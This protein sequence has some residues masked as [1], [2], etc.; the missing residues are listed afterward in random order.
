MNIGYAIKTVRKSLRL[1]QGG[2]AKRTG[3]A[4]S[5]F[6]QV[7]K[8]RKVPSVK[9]ITAIAKALEVPACLIYMLGMEASDIQPERKFMYDALWPTIEKM[10]LEIITNN[11][12]HTT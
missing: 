8:N 1:N 6:S 5:Y 2:L 3:L 4:Q 11:E 7:E 10:T 12:P 9:S